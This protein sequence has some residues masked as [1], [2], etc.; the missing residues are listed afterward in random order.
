LARILGGLYVFPVNREHIITACRHF[1]FHDRPNTQKASIAAVPAPWMALFPSKNRRFLVEF[2][3]QTPRI[4]ISMDADFYPALPHIFNVSKKKQ[5][6][7]PCFY[8]FWKRL[9]F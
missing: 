2:A 9:S 4:K 1:P 5:T 6:L 8:Y 3:K 7:K